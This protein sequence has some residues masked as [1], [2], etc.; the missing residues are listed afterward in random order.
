MI[1]HPCFLAPGAETVTS[2]DGTLG[3]WVGDYLTERFWRSQNPNGVR[4][5][6]NHHRTVSTYLNALTDHRFQ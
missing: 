3:R 1:G 2:S 6:G 5:A 4:R